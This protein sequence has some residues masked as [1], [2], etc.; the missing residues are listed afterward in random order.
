MNE[1]QRHTISKVWKLNRLGFML[2][3]WLGVLGW[4]FNG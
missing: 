3:T 2:G 4:L 1:R